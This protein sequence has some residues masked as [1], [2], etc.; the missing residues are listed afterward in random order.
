M[1][2]LT[3]TDPRIAQN[4]G[5]KRIR[6]VLYGSI[7]DNSLLWRRIAFYCCNFE[8]NQRYWNLER[9]PV[10]DSNTF[11]RLAPFQFLKSRYDVP[12]NFL[13]FISIEDRTD[14]RDQ[15]FFRITHNFNEVIQLEAKYIAR[16][17]QGIPGY[18]QNVF[19]PWASG[20]QYY[21]NPPGTR[22]L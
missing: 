19:H 4:R 1:K 5:K 6:C 7:C 17:F 13:W 20:R 15:N 9:P 8:E 21:F 11:D 16:H 18:L 14:T 12:D 10:G 2:L 22:M 3:S